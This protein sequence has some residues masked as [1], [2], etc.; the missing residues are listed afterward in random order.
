MALV[1]AIAGLAADRERARGVVLRGRVIALGLCA[2]AVST[3]AAATTG[4]SPSVSA[5]Y[6][7]RIAGIELASFNFTSTVRGE[8]YTLAGH[9]KLSWGLGLYKYDG[10]F[11]GTGTLA[12]DGVRPATYAYDWKVNK[13]S[14]SVRLGF[15]RGSVHKVEIQPP[16]TSSPDVVPL[17]PEHLMSVFDPLTALIALSRYRGGDPC[18]R[19]IALFEGKQ[20]FDLVLTRHREEKVLEPKPSGQPVLAHI[21]RVRYL[22]VAGHKANR[23]TQAAIKTE[24]I[25]VALRPIPSANLLVPYRITIPTPLGNAILTAQ[26]VD[27]TG[28][29]NKQIALTH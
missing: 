25:E 14:G 9:G 18:D 16:H 12:G 21:C 26:R 6:K 11:T 24:G 2:L 4:W 22:P 1:A 7:L 28:P 29:G 10:K 20:R 13:K 23:E 19:R 17:K 8:A 15:D 3:Q 27:I 5:L